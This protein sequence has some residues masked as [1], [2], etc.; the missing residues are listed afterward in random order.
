MSSVW[1]KNRDGHSDLN[2]Q[3]SEPRRRSRANSLRHV[4]VLLTENVTDFPKH[5]VG[6]SSRDSSSRYR[7]KGGLMRFADSVEK[8]ID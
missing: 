1:L 2:C 5:D 8:L 4:D 3:K 6:A 7:R